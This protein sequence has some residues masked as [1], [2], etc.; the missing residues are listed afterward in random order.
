V[1][2]ATAN[3][4][5]GVDDYGWET[6]HYAGMPG[7]AH[8]AGPVH[9]GGGYWGA[10]AAGSPITCQAC[11]FETVAAAPGRFFFFDPTGSY[12]FT[13]AE[14]SPLDPTRT[15]YESWQRTQCATCHA[16][17][18]REGVVVPRRH[19]NGRRDVVF[20]ARAALPDGH[21]TGLPTLSVPG[22]V[23][24]YY[25]TIP[26]DSWIS[27]ALDPGDCASAAAPSCGVGQDVAWRAATDGQRV[28]TF[29]LEHARY[30][31]A[32]RTCTSVACHLDRQVQLDRGA[33]GIAPL[34]WGGTYGYDETCSGCHPY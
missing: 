23:R 24:P 30:D 11:H 27:F 28:L 25:A 15:A 21:V 19:V 9:G 8:G 26:A 13:P 14:R 4:H 3:S 20:D 22:P 6:G 17:E 31:P 32:T 29:T 12:S 2:A 1:G 7:P 16:G 10:S 34:R 5:L 33:S 18:A